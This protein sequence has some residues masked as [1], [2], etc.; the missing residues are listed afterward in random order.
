MKTA[1]QKNDGAWFRANRFLKTLGDGGKE[2]LIVELESDLHVIAMFAAATDLAAVAGY[3]ELPA[4]L[5]SVDDWIRAMLST[6]FPRQVWS[7][8]LTW[9]TYTASADVPPVYTP[10]HRDAWRKGAH[11]IRRI[12]TRFRLARRQMLD[13]ANFLPATQGNP[14][15]IADADIVT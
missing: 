3:T 14:G 9:D 11:A 4:E 2:A 6:G 15:G 5:G 8:T 10:D 13:F 7:G 12:H 1:G